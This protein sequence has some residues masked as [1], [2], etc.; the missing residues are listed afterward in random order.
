MAL[1]YISFSV[2]QSSTKSSSSSCLVNSKWQLFIRFFGRSC[3]K[4]QHQYHQQSVIGMTE[5]ES[6]TETLNFDDHIDIFKMKSFPELLR[7][8]FIFSLC[9]LDLLVKHSSSLL[10]IGEKVLGQRLMSAI[11]KPTLYGQFVAGETRMEIERTTTSLESAGIGSLLGM[12]M[13]QDADDNNAGDRHAWYEKNHQTMIDAITLVSQLDSH[14][15][16]THAKLT[17]LMP[18]DVLVTLSDLYPKPTDHSAVISHLAQCMKTGQ[19]LEIPSLNKKELQELQMCLEKLR[20]I[21]EYAVEKDVIF[22]FDAEHTYVNPGLNMLTLAMMLN[23]NISK[24]L[25]FFTYQSYLK[26]STENLSRDVRF[27]QDQGVK[28]GAKIVRG[29]YMEL[30]RTRAKKHGYDDPVNDTYEDT[31]NR[32]ERNVENMLIKISKYPLNYRIMIATHN[33]QSIQRLHSKV[34][35]YGIIKQSGSVFFGQIY[36]MGDHVSFTLGSS[37]VLIYKALPYG[38]VTETLAYLVRR[39]QE[40]RAILKGARR[41]KK[42]IEQSLKGRIAFWRS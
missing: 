35:E 33:E 25:I 20:T 22:M 8:Y 2:I 10:F 36:G 11:L 6:K 5:V 23:Y 7:S 42:L 26:G 16:M 19:T 24:P 17:A 14:F 39:M 15:P 31:C 32:Y 4:H 38:P 37:N 21:G 12:P 18:A 30:E 29:A 40:N 34:E 41:E 13:E 3:Y 27:V 9:S 28:L 1:R